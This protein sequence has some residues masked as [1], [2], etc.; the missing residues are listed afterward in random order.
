MGYPIFLI[1]H[2]RSGTTLVQRILNTVD[3]VAILGEHGGYLSHIADAYHSAMDRSQSRLM[4]SRDLAGIRKRLGQ[5]EIWPG[6]TNALDH[7]S[8]R[9]NFAAMLRS[10]FHP[11][12]EPVGYWGFKEIRYGPDDGVLEMLTDAFPRARFVFIARHPV[13]TVAS[14]R[15]FHSA[16]LPELITRWDAKY[17]YYN[18]FLMSH[19]DICVLVRYE[20]V[21]AGD[22]MGQLLKALGLRCTD[23]QREVLALEDGRYA[24]PVRSQGID[25]IYR[26]NSD[27]LRR[28]YCGTTMSRKLLGYRVEGVVKKH[29]DVTTHKLQDEDR[30]L[31]M[32]DGVGSVFTD[33]AGA[34]ILS[35]CDGAHTRQ[36]ITAE[37]TGLFENVPNDVDGEVDTTLEVLIRHGLI[38]LLPIP[39]CSG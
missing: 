39:H 28:I 24:S 21:L 2:A 17:R 16:S 13:N 26:L 18:D 7:P 30:Y 20:D 23:T 14:A 8:L 19:P 34:A 36:T 5:P 3:D 6:W 9:A 27:E 32:R 4:E 12:D 15:I 10:M 1:G 11:W 33:T 25:P 29:T 31:V 22:G 37:L 38:E 35:L